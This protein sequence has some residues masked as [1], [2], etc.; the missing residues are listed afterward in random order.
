MRSKQLEAQAYPFRSS[1]DR[2]AGIGM[3]IEGRAG[4]GIQVTVEPPLIL[5][6]RPGIYTSEARAILT[7]P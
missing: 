6:E 3:L 4:G 2:D 1:T 7:S 5:Y